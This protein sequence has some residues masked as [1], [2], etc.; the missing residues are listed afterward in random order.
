MGVHRKPAIIVAGPGT[1]VPSMDLFNVDKQVSA[2]SILLTRLTAA[3][4]T[5]YGAYHSNR[6][7]VLIHIICVPILLWYIIALCLTTLI[8]RCIGPS[9]FSQ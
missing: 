5:F 3:Q 6:I 9:K 1:C 7:N 8:D 4:L 2:L